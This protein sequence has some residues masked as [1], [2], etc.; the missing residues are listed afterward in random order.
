MERERCHADVLRY[1]PR[2]KSTVGRCSRF[3]ERRSK[4]CWQHEP[5]FLLRMMHERIRKNRTTV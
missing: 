3:A 1:R 2:G 4:W 5:A